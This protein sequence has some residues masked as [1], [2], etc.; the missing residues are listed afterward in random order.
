I[1]ALQGGRPTEAIRDLQVAGDGLRTF[2]KTDPVDGQVASQLAI[3]LVFLS[4]ALREDHRPAEAL[5]LLREARQVLEDL[6]Q[7]SFVDLYNLACTYA[8]LSTLIDPAAAPVSVAEQ[9][10]LA[11]RAMASLRLSIA[12]GMS[13]FALMDRDHDLDPLRERADFRALNLEA[14]GRLREAVPYLATMASANPKDTLLSL[15]VAALQAWFGQEKE[16]AATRQRILAFAKGTSDVA[17][18]ERVSKACSIL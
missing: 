10:A 11:D 2:H 15:K 14:N 7:P 4:S 13:D 8:H 3:S 6:R 17:M 12:A 1:G 5:A 18:A 16:L 9:E